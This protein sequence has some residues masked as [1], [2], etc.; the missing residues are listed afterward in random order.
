MD[1][2]LEDGGAWV[3]ESSGLMGW[4]RRWTAPLCS[5]LTRQVIEFLRS[6]SDDVRMTL[7]AGVLPEPTHSNTR[8]VA[9]QIASQNDRLFLAGISRTLGRLSLPRATA[10]LLGVAIVSAL[11][12]HWILGFIPVFRP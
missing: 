4:R 5:N 7:N 3:K 11:A 2:K 12:L 8:E 9:A 1:L 6:H 10:V